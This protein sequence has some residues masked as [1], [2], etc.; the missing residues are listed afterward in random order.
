[1]DYD[2]TFKGHQTQENMHKEGDEEHQ[3]H[4]I[5]SMYAVPSMLIEGLTLLITSGRFGPIETSRAKT[6]L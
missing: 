3:D 5:S 1:M 2:N 6:T 4:I